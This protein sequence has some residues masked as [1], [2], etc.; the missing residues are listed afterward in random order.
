LENVTGPVT[1]GGTVSVIV[2]GAPRV[3]LVDDTTG[4]GSTGVSLL[5]V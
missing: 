3:G 4:M 5:T 2:T 1:P